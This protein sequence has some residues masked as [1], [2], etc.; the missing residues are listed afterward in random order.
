MKGCVCTCAYACMHT[1]ACIRVHV[2]TH[3]SVGVL[4]HVYI[5]L[6][7]GT[8]Q[9]RLLHKFLVEGTSSI[10]VLAEMKG[11]HGTSY[12]ALFC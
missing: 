10:S 2:C 12:G 7:T 5:L 9:W 1:R 4:A 8:G 6:F 11:S 3:M